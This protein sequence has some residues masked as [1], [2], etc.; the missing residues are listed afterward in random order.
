MEKLRLVDADTL[1]STPME[2]TVFIVEGLIPQG[3]TVL[4]GSGKIGKSWLMLWLGLRAAQGLPLWD[5]ATRK[6]DV[7]YLCL[8]DTQGRI[9][10]RLYRLT[11]EAPAGLRFAIACGRLGGGLEGQIEEALED[12]PETQ[13]VI[14]DTLQKV[15]DPQNAAGRSG[16]YASDYEDISALKAIADRHRIAVVLV[17]HV[18]KLKD[19]SDPF[20]EVSGSTGITGAADTNII[21][22]RGR[23]DS[24]ATLLVCGRDVDYQQFTL[25]FENNVWHLVERKDSDTLRREEIPTFLF[26]V[27]DFMRDRPQW[28]GTATELLAAMPGTDTPVNTVTK[29]LARFAGEVLAPAGIEYRTKRTGTSRLICFTRSDG[30]DGNDGNR[31]VYKKTVTAVT[32]VTDQSVMPPGGNS[33]HRVCVAANPAASRRKGPGPCDPVEERKEVSAE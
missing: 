14:I 27:V 10:E 25:R 9:Q 12:Y 24:T 16:M 11:D 21:L 31:A 26:Q 22:K 29:L 13:L 2:K 23:G 7:L 19:A 5:L 20:N 8:E 32:A 6:C 15:R 17:H 28:N 18:R 33:E 3:V 30:C 1:L 4:S